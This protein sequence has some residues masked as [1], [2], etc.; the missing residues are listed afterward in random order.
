MLTV[1]S[2]PSMAETLALNSTSTPSASSG[3]TTGLVNRAEYEVTRLGSPTQLVTTRS[4]VPMVS[5]P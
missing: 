5:I 3:T 4:A 2:D 1:T